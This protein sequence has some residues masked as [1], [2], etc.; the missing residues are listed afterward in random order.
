MKEAKLTSFMGGSKE[1]EQ[2]DWTFARADTRY[3]THGLHPY[4]ARMI[5]QVAGKLIDLYDGSP[6][7]VC[8]DPF[9]GS[10]TVLVE[11]KLRGVN[12]IGIDANPLAVLLSKVK[13]TPIDSSILE[14]GESHLMRNVLSDLDSKIEP[15][16]PQIKNLDFW[17]KPEVSKVL[18]TIRTNIY[19]IEDEDLRDFFRVCLSITAR[20]VSNNRQREFK[21]YRLAPAD[22]AS[23]KPDV[24]GVFKKI[25]R[26]NVVNMKEY[27]AEA[28]NSAKVT[29]LRGDTRKALELKPDIL[30]EQS[31]TMLITSPPYGDS[32]TTVAYGQFSRYPALWAGFPEEEVWKVDRNALGGRVFKDERDIES[33]TLSNTLVEIA[34]GDKH[35][36]DETYAFF[37]DID[38]CFGQF[39]KIMKK[40]KSHVCFVLGNRTVKRVR[41]PADQILIELARKYGFEHLVTKHREI[42]NKHIPSSNAPE[43]VQDLKGETMTKE[44]III[45]KY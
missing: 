40:R 15:D 9:C 33:P 44:N 29:V 13:S 20:K 27:S 43:N 5:P 4:P 17:F 38:E 12:A 24:L 37:R 42:P 11:S 32:H 8:L 18:A 31:A 7:D 41:V 45:W 21:L 26:A 34:K 1:P 35:R 23:H 3:M 30:H 2:E 25:L 19:R 16:I 10:G 14:K 6:D 36:A 28:R 22:L 39:S